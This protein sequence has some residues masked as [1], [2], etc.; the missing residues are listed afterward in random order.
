M[1]NF[2]HIISLNINIVFWNIFSYPLINLCKSLSSILLS[3]TQ[4]STCLLTVNILAVVLGLVNYTGIV[5]K[6]GWM[7]CN[8]SNWSEDVISLL[9]WYKG[10]KGEPIYSIDSRTTTLSSSKHVKSNQ[11]YFVNIDNLPP[12]LI[13]DPIE[14]SDQGVYHCRVDYKNDRTQHHFTFLSIVGKLAV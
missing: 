5:G 6:R 12:D 13:I 9:L 11:R 4:P 3:L 10:N 1:L 14:E 7:N 8:T 2:H